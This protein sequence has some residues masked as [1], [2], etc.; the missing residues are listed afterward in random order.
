[1]D[2]KPFDARRAVMQFFETDRVWGVDEVPVPRAVLSR[3]PASDPGGS[4]QVTGG[5]LSPDEKRTRLGVLDEQKVKPCTSCRLAEGRTNTVFGVG[6]ADAR[7]VFVGEGPGFE[8]DR[9]GIPFVGRAGQLLDRMIVAMGTRRAD[10]YI[11]NVVKCRPPNNRDPAADEIAAC[12]R[13]LFE[14]LQVIDPQVI[15][16]LG[17]PASRTL[18]NTTEPIG[19]LRGRFHDFTVGDPLGG[20]KVVPLMPTYHPAYLLR[21]PHQKVKTWADM[22]MVMKL[23][24]LTSPVAPR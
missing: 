20:G 3:R 16:A 11:C 18:L 8:E 21:S 10:V 12:S 9:Q 24:G 2:P 6:N 23:L 7:L 19:K 13:Y 5:G 14:Q 17:A 15:V 1:M 4:G 22:K